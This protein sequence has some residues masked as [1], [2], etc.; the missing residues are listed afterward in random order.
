MLEIIYT[1]I[2]FLSGKGQINT[3]G[4]SGAS[5]GGRGGRGYSGMRAL[6][7]YGN[8]F[9]NSSWGSGGGSHSPFEKTGG[10]GGGY[11]YINATTSVKI[12]GQIKA[13]GGNAK[14]NI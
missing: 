9:T 8:I 11:L 10:R 3:Q 14:V 6:H 2:L 13:N 1:C 4:A 7:S 12:S 5:H